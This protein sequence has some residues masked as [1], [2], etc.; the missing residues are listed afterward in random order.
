MITWLGGWEVG[1]LEGW[2]RQCAPFLAGDGRVE[3][4]VD[5]AR[6]ILPPASSTRYS[7]AQL[8]DYAG[9]SR[10]NFPHRPPLRLALRARFS[11]SAE[12]N[13][14]DAEDAD[15]FS[16]SQARSDDFSRPGAEATEV[17]TTSVRFPHLGSGLIGTAG[18]GFWNNPVGPQSKIPALPQAIWF[19]YA[20]PPSNLSLAFGLTGCGGKA[21][22]LDAGRASA[23]AW[24]PV[25][26]LVML[27]CRSPRLYRAIWP[28]VERALMISERLLAFK[29]GDATN[30]HTYE[31]EW[32]R[33]GARWRVDGETVLETDRSPRGPLGFVA[34]IDNQYA[35]VTSQGNFKF[36]LL[37]APFE[38]W[39][40]VADVDLADR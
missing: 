30:W 24:A 7:D 35:V 22:C 33:D 23:L 1:G 8:D 3:A 28:R 16:R 9:L 12:S 5:G 6:L 13:R 26:P 29:Q 17:A 38:Q 19:F 27:A 2:L 14:S 31:L 32:R 37:D 36:G 40:E 39:M 4:T 18:F 21:A 34:W 25:A 20:S 15:R 10:R 11:H